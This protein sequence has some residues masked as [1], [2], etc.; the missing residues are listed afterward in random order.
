[1]SS[2]TFGVIHEMDTPLLAT[3][4][5]VTEATI[6]Q[7]LKK[8]NCVIFK[9]KHS[10]LKD[11]ETFRPTLDKLKLNFG[12]RLPRYIQNRSVR[13]LVSQNLWKKSEIFCW[14]KIIDVVLFESIHLKF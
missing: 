2:K 13:K 5:Y 11:I 8:L 3:K 1:M 4:F 10:K 9:N 12:T 6:K 14:I 7:D